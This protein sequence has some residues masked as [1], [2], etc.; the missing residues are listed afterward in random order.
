VKER[1][2]PDEEIP[3]AP[4]TQRPSAVSPRAPRTGIFRWSS[5]P[6][7]DEPPGVSG[8]P[9]PRG[10]DPLSV[11]LRWTEDLDDERAVTL[12]SG[13]SA[14]EDPQAREAALLRWIDWA[15]VAI[16][17]GVK[18]R[19]LVK[20]VGRLIGE[21]AMLVADADR[22]LALDPIDL[23]PVTRALLGWLRAREAQPG[24]VLGAALSIVQASE[25]LREAG[26]TGSNPVSIP[27]LLAALRR[28]MERA[29]T[30]ECAELLA[31][32]LRADPPASMAPWAAMHLEFALLAG[33]LRGHYAPALARLPFVAPAVWRDL[34]GRR[35]APR[36]TLRAMRLL[37][38]LAQHD[39]LA[40]ALPEETAQLAAE[41]LLAG[42]EH[43]RFRVWSLAARAMGRLAGALPA[44][45]R[46]LASLLGQVGATLLRRRAFAALGNVGP[47]GDPALRA[48]RDAVI[49]AVERPVTAGDAST[50]VHTVETG[51]WSLSLASQ[52]AAFAVSLPDHVAHGDP[53]WSALA[54]A[55]AE[56]GGPDAWLAVARAMQEVALRQPNALEAAREVAASV[57]SKAIGV[58]ASSADNERAER[59]EAITVRLVHPDAPRAPQ[60]LLAELAHA[61]GQSPSAPDARSLVDGCG[62]EL[63]AV[64]SRAVRSL[65][66]EDSRDAAQGSLA[67]EE[68]VDLVVDGDLEVLAHHLGEVAART[69]ALALVDALRD[70]LL[71]MVW[72]GLRRSTP[73]AAA[74]RRWLL[75]SATVLPRVP[76]TNRHVA[77]ETVR[78]QVIE[79]LERVAEDPL[80][81]QRA[82]E[83]HVAA[84]LV[85][86]AAALVP[87]L[88][89]GAIGAVMTW[90]AL[91]GVLGPTQVRMRRWIV[92]DDAG[93]RVQRWFRL[94]ELLAR[95]GRDA[96]ADLGALQGMVG[97][98]CRLGR[99]LGELS[100]CCA[101][102]TTRRPED[103]WSGL[104]RFDLTDFARVAD[105]FTR[106]T[107]D[108]TFAL[109][110]DHERPVP[111]TR[112]SRAAHATLS[113][114][115]AQLDRLL[116][117]TS[118]KFVDAARRAEVVEHYLGELGALCE[119]IATGCG[120]L[121][122]SLVRGALA[123]AMVAV[124]TMAA[125]AVRT[126]TTGS[127]HIGR[128]RVLGELSSAHEG[129]MAST[130]LAEGP[131]PGKRVVVKLLPW[132]GMRG[133]SAETS[134]A[135]FEGEMERLA[136]VVHPNI[137]GIVDAGF[138]DEGAY[139]A[140]EY[141]P[142]ASLE[143]LLTRL[144]RMTPVALAPI[145]RDVARALAH[146]HQRGVLHRDVK[147]ANLLAQFE[148]ADGEE[149]TAE[150]L[151]RAELIRAVLIDFGIATETSRAGAHEGITGTP[152]YIAPEVVRGIEPFGPAVDVY[153]L[154]V[155][156]F[157]MLCGTN[158]FLAGEPDLET[159][160]VR[161]GSVA[162][163]WSDLPDITG[164]TALVKLLQDATRM[165]PRQR[166]TMRAFLHRWIELSAGF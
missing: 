118:L 102:L 75:R 4:V 15:G 164:R 44:V 61:V 115:A 76:P 95:S 148:L 52:V 49:A 43:P 45:T 138:V 131:A 5:R 132:A 160:L 47:D 70:R 29:P 144:G 135:L 141:I 145:I 28:R 48:H 59:A 37:A 154:A 83:R 121:L 99:T 31:V 100:N 64:I 81:G 93:D 153:A 67:L 122:S 105:T 157:E 6:A 97:D 38:A 14:V 32:Y 107:L 69:A 152:G 25:T 161:H 68:V 125:A 39:Q 134:R 53:R 3:E 51:A 34:L 11:L 130:F 162:L 98:H 17:L 90:M 165:D 8:P 117:S 146:L 163:P 155:V 140:L 1:T 116:T 21:L 66:R 103:H 156:V 96:A 128:L 42:L 85:E 139:L 55:F 12:W 151:S 143:T 73:A 109:T 113:E 158:P 57:Q 106:L 71:K 65:A 58:R 40:R 56:R 77:A 72:S 89:T 82:L 159:V 94:V 20:A 19:D 30:E 101:S 166:P 13:L 91:R 149:L 10:P 110:L 150:S 136:R 62:A 114:R 79:T 24:V 74:W 22:V 126:E 84:A 87:S 104:P 2:N 33:D 142:G 129:G 60:A 88:G 80:A 112:I 133:T 50:S 54:T 46:A 127:R 16:P 27:M 78:D 124:R 111:A 119:A 18:L 86:L 123:R 108:A 7:E 36:D 137:V 23:A 147:P 120:P 63:D 92:D 35:E 9:K 41:A 26:G